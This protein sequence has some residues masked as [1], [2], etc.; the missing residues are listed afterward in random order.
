M[1]K[2]ARTCDTSRTGNL[3]CGCA[4]EPRRPAMLSAWEATESAAR[5]LGVT[6]Q[7][8]ADRRL[9]DFEPAFG[10]LALHRPGAL[11]VQALDDLHS[12]KVSV[13]AQTGL[14]FDLGTASGSSC[15]HSSA[16]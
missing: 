5:K 15:V 2:A 12:W 6:L 3:S 8:L 9:A 13:L 11:L 14:S 16:R 1:G 7:S 4:L 10:T